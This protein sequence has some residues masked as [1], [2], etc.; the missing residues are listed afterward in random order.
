MRQLAL[1][2]FRREHLTAGAV[3]GLA[4]GA[5][6]R[7]RSVATFPGQA[8]AWPGG[9]KLDLVLRA[10]DPYAAGR[11]GFRPLGLI[12]GVPPVAADVD[13]AA[14]MNTNLPDL[15]RQVREPQMLLLPADQRPALLQRPFLFLDLGHSAIWRAWGMSTASVSWVLR[16][17]L[18]SS[19]QYKGSTLGRRAVEPWNGM[20]CVFRSDSLA[21]FMFLLGVVSWI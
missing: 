6:D 7:G 17:G 19:S 13:A 5:I 4:T 9:N 3:G 12:A 10:G 20:Q 14:V 8:G 21:L 15:A 1:L 11:E 18:A 16:H 2:A